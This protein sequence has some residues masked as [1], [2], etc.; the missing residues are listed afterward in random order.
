MGRY[1]KVQDIVDLLADWNIVSQIVGVKEG[2]LVEAMTSFLA[3][4]G[5][6]IEKGEINSLKVDQDKKG[7]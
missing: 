2:N 4:M 5:G 3:T 1:V 7:A 6:M